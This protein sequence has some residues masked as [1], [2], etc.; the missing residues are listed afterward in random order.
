MADKAT[1]A[2]HKIEDTVVG[3]FNKISDKF[4]GSFLSK[5]GESVEEAKTRIV[6]EQSK[7]EAA[8]K[9]L[10]DRSWREVP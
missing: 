10:Q 4:A 5:E 8:Q 9:A 6:D 7:R 2:F 1:G 3:T